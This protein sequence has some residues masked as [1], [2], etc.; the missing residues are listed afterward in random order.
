[1]F[2]KINGERENRAEASVLTSLGVVT[3]VQKPEVLEGGTELD[4]RGSVADAL[5]RAGGYGEEADVVLFRAR[6]TFR[7]AAGDVQ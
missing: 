1:M 3:V 6:R 5:A 7:G 4:T 2:S